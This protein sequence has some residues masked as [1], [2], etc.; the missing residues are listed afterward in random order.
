MGTT[1]RRSTYL[2]STRSSV[3]CKKRYETVSNCGAGARN[4]GFHFR[5]VFHRERNG[6]NAVENRS[7]CSADRCRVPAVVANGKA[8]LTGTMRMVMWLALIRLR[9]ATPRRALTLG[10]KSRSIGT[11]RGN[12]LWPRGERSRIGDLAQ[13][14]KRFSLS[15][16][17]RA[18][19][20]PAVAG[21]GRAGGVRENVALQ[22]HRSGL[23]LIRKLPL[24]RE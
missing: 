23:E 3:R 24:T 10:L 17:E 1:P 18:G 12:H 4:S 15:Q 19:P 13:R 9:C 14:G 5:C 22:L 20:S 8:T 11:R 16:R 7:G 6:R 21:F 2:A